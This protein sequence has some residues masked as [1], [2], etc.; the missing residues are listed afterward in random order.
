MAFYSTE[1]VKG[2]LLTVALLGASG[3]V[4]TTLLSLLAQSGEDR[5]VVL[6]P[7]PLPDVHMRAMRHSQCAVESIQSSSPEDLVPR[8]SAARAVICVAGATSVDAGL[9]DPGDVCRQNIALAIGLGELLRMTGRP[10][11]YLSSD[12]VL[13]A[14][15]KP[16]AEASELRPTQPYAA[17]KACSEIILHNY[18][19]VYGLRIST[20]RSC[21]LV[22]PYQSSPKFLPVLVQA[23]LNGWPVPIHGS[24]RQRRQWMH[25][26]DICSAVLCLLSHDCP[27]GVFQGTTGES[28]SLLQVVQVAA[29]CL[30]LSAVLEHV[31]DRLVQDFSYGMSSSALNLLGWTPT[32]SATE[33][34]ERA[35]SEL[36]ANQRKSAMKNSALE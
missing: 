10:A 27:V 6:D 19:D 22:G 8:V 31:P 32:M 36:A 18:R 5:V 14:S 3:F 35:A 13:G 34:I 20:L 21:N 30:Q 28:L 12:E 24:G 17:S 29:D 4:G 23:L 25:V 1:R 15:R 26:E 9:A 7:K 16:L 2:P 33:A 11:I